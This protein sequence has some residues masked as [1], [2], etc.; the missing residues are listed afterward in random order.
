[1]KIHRKLNDQLWSVDC[2]NAYGN[3]KFSHLVLIYSLLY[4]DS[5]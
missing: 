5:Q 3:N 2:L 1:M 4:L